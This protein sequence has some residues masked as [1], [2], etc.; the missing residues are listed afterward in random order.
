[1]Q[2]LLFPSQ[3]ESQQELQPF[4][5]QASQ[6]AQAQAVQQAAQQASQQLLREAKVR[7]SL[8]KKRFIE[9][10]S[11]RGFFF[12]LLRPCPIAKPNPMAAKKAVRKAAQVNT[13][14]SLLDIPIYS[15]VRGAIKTA[16]ESRW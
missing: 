11:C 5:Q 10:F 8:L 1:I 3:Q 15:G 2:A 14:I 12:F 16:T 6:Q 4:W 7:R 13:A 9:R